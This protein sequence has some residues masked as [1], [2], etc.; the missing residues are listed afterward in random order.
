MSTRRSYTLAID[1][2]T[3][4]SRACLFDPDGELIFQQQQAVDLHRLDHHRVEQDAAQILQTVLWCTRAACEHAEA[5]QLPVRHCGLATQ[6]SSVLAWDAEGEAVSPVL[7]WQDTRAAGRLET[8]PSRPQAIQQITGLPLSP[9]YGAS[10]LA[11]LQTH[12]NS[13]V[14]QTNLRLSPLVSYLAFH[15]LAQRPYIVDHANAQRTQLFSLQQLN[16][17]ERLCRHFSVS[18][19]SL[20]QCVPVCAAHGRL[21]HHNV[22]LR[23]ISGD[24]NAAIY[25]NGWLPHDTALVN[26]GSGAFVLQTLPQYSPSKLLL[27]GIACSSEQQ[28][29]YLREGTVNG[30]G[31]ALQWL[32]RQHPEVPIDE[33]LP[34]WLLETDKP[35]VFIN[36][37]GALG[38]P[39]WNARLAPQFITDGCTLTVAEK[40]VAVVES[41]VF[42]LSANLKIMRRQQHIKRIQISGGLSRLDGLCQRLADLNG[43]PVERCTVTEATARG[44]AWLAAGQP[45]HW[46]QPPLQRFL[47]AAKT[48]LHTRYQRMLDV[49]GGA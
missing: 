39:W 43:L 22:L 3:H 5:R 7:S 14:Q 44:I 21:Q 16:W 31:S 48:A 12:S 46:A 24:Q 27:T 40:A 13:P 25:Q 6:R 34:R 8:L 28:V 1:Q 17:D 10:K 29:H 9:H 47:P 32:Q 26:V 23:A 4:A 2:G 45:E 19:T 18:R 37:V 38:S 15:L 33:H 30:A 35:P 41:I 42:M 49:L 11:W 36:S 20:P